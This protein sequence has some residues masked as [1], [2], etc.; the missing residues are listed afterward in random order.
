MLIDNSTHWLNFKGEENNTVLYSS[1]RLFRNIAEKRFVDKASKEDLFNIKNIFYETI[2]NTK[3]SDYEYIELYE[4]KNLNISIL[5]EE[6]V[7]PEKII[8]DNACLYL[9]NS[10]S[11]SILINFKEHCL[12]E[13]RAVGLNF[14]DMLDSTLDIENTLDKY[15]NFAFDERLGY[16]TST[17]KKIGCAMTVYASLSLPVLLH[18]NTDAIEN[19]VDKCEK[20]GLKCIIRKPLYKEPIIHVHNKSMIGQTEK[21]IVDSIVSAIAGIVSI[22]KK[23]RD[24]LFKI[25]RY[26]IEDKI[27]RSKAI[28]S[29]AREL[30]YSE[31]IRHIMWL[32]VGIYYNILDTE[33]AILDKIMITARPC[34]ILVNKL[35]GKNIK[36]Y[37]INYERA[38]MIRGLKL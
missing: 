24:R 8:V 1:I 29:E 31:F 25:D 23:V 36:E 12:I 4:E 21:A 17:P 32:R 27:F 16:L 5:K 20:L 28:L 38:K 22:E 26:K 2:K 34:H 15:I 33:I 13:S 37:N 6:G 3:L 18:W 19:F 11:N 14:N 10:Q 7:I 9:N 30:S 35:H